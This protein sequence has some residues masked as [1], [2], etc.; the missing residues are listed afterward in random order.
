ML[1]RKVTS[2]AAGHMTAFS[3][4]FEKRGAKGLPPF[5]G[6]ITF[7]G[8]FNALGIYERKLGL[9]QE[10]VLLRSGFNT[11]IYTIFRPL[12]LD[13]TL[14]GALILLFFS[15]FVAGIAYQFV[16]IGKVRFVPLLTAFYATVMFSFNTSLWIWNT[17][18]IGFVGYAGLLWFLP[19][20]KRRSSRASLSCD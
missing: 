16:L 7:A 11:N 9:F 3:W 20:I 14:F 1:F 13:F 10:F 6:Q 12:I 8:I 2:G 15:G 19:L 4:W 18:L 17:V 5:L